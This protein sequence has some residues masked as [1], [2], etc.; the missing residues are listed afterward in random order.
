MKLKY[1]F[2]NSNNIAFINYYFFTFLKIKI[3]KDMPHLL[4]FF[5]FKKEGGHM[6]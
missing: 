6:G 3:K 5:F 4:E 2:E 1:Y